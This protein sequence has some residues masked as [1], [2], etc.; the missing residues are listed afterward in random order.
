MQVLRSLLSSS[1]RLPP[2]VFMWLAAA[3]YIAGAASHLLTWPEVIARAGLWP[4]IAAQALLIWIWYSLHVKRLRDAGRG[5][6]LAAGVSLLYALSVVLL[7][8]VAATFYH[9]LVG[10]VPDAN[11]ASALGLILVAGIVAILLGSPHYDVASLMV[12][13]LL[14]LAFV[15]LILAVGLSVWAATLPSR[16]DGPGHALT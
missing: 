10:D 14:L 7:I 12:A 1:G 4:F 16:N 11:A 8:V 3:V 13:I 6:G 15:P 5:A 2:Y 9:A